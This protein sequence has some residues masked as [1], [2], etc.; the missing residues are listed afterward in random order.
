MWS[1]SRAI[2]TYGSGADFG[3][4]LRVQCIRRL[5][6]GTERTGGKAS[7]VQ[8]VDR[9]ASARRKPLQVH[10]TARSDAQT[11]IKAQIY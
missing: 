10:K 6:T 7:P 4:G 9:Q 3:V 5:S 2:G 8:M 11:F 1:H